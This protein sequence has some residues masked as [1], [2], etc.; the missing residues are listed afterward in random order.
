MDILTLSLSWGIIFLFA[1]PAYVWY[2]LA[3]GRMAAKAG[4]PQWA[5][6]VPIYN[7]VIFYRLA[8]RSSAL[9]FTFFTL[10]LA[11]E[12][13]GLVVFLAWTAND[14]YSSSLG[15]RLAVLIIS[16]IVAAAL[17]LAATINLW[18]ATHR[19][20][21][22]FGLGGGFTALGIFF[23]LIWMSVVAWGSAQWQ[24]PSVS[25]TSRVGGQAGSSPAGTVSVDSASRG[26]TAPPPPPTVQATVVGAVPPPP[27][28]P[29]TPA[30]TVAPPTSIPAPPAPPATRP[31]GPGRSPWE[32]PITSAPLPTPA[33]ASMPPVPPARPAP[34]ASPVAPSAQPSMTNGPIT[35]PAPTAS[36]VPVEAVQA[37]PPVPSTAH[38]SMG[39][40][41]DDDGATVAAPSRGFELDDEDDRTVIAPRVVVPRFAL[42]LEDGTRLP[43]TSDEV[44][45]GRKPSSDRDRPQAQLL[46]VPDPTKT[47]SKN[48]ALLR[49]DGDEWLVTDLASTNGVATYAAGG[50]ET[51]LPAGAPTVVRGDFALGQARMRVEKES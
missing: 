44:I 40:D 51:V 1:L 4:E 33:A 36:Q 3:L 16:I 15:G 47:M 19:V 35:Q 9:Y 38:A 11:I 31:A 30:G 37:H 12:F 41:D 43:L 42:V 50:E 13:I 2:A 39:I 28:P 23:P 48:H 34:P 5:G 7:L 46:S 29:A 20:N 49:R 45:L 25:Q 14:P 22:H 8:R 21:I 27:P 18:I 10:G 17:Q 32:P 24:G 6:W 26:A